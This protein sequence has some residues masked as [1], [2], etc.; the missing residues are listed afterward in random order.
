MDRQLFHTSPHSKF[1]DIAHISHVSMSTLS[2]HDILYLNDLLLTNGF[3]QVLV[4]NID[5]GS[6]IIETFLMCLN[7]YQWIYSLSNSRKNNRGI[8]NLMDELKNYG[9]LEASSCAIYQAYFSEQFYADCLVIECTYD[10]LIKQ[11]YGSFYKSL[12][13]V[14]IAEHMPIIQLISYQDT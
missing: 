9:C 10:L 11:W 3:H 1:I 8:C 13:D 4:K 2:E 6:A 14:E 12:C 5:L 7:K